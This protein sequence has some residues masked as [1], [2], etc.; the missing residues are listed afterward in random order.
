M[1]KNIIL[2]L[3]SLFLLTGCG[4][5]RL[6]CSA[7]DEDENYKI[8]V[9]YTFIYNQGKVKKATMKS[10]A[11]LLGD[12]NN[13]TIIAERENAAR[14]SAENYN[15]VDGIEAVVS[16]KG[17]KVTLTVDILA[18][19]L[20]EENKELYSMNMKKEELKQVMTEEGYTCK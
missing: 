10:T 14:S 15:K 3:I 5:N 1:K 19:A 6:V 8:E 20:S 17:N 11:T 18:A 7:Q 4:E 2:V 9:K 13:D 16:T 12:Y